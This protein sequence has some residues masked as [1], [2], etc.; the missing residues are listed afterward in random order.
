MKQPFS[1]HAR[2]PRSHPDIDNMYYFIF[3]VSVVFVRRDHRR[4]YL[5]RGR[6]RASTEPA[7]DARPVTT[8]CSELF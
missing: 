3:W 7:G 8:T 6:Y 5:L 1:F 2:C 4:R